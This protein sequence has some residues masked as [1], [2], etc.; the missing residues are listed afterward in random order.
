M[1]A[2]VG[3]PSSF[4]RPSLT[5]RRRPTR[6]RE[7]GVHRTRPAGQHLCR[8]SRRRSG[9]SSSFESASKTRAAATGCTMELTRRALL[10]TTAVLG[11]TAVA[12]CGVAPQIESDG[13]VLFAAPLSTIPVVGTISS[14]SVRRIYCVGRNYAAHARE[15]GS[16][17]TREPPFFFQKPR[18]AVQLV[19]RGRDDRPSLPADDEELPLRS[20]ARRGAGQG[21]RRTSRSSAR[22]DAGL[23]LRRRP[24]HDAP[25]SAAH[26]GRSAEAVGAGQ[27]VR[28][29]RGDHAP[30]PG[31]RRPATSPRARSG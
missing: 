4:P 18:D 10:H 24:R 16:D 25:R 17:P 3:S 20:G 27:G 2:R 30:A 8:R 14:F 9:S 11:T 26:D 19:A 6:R 13:N 5:T 12:G 1:R 7:H 28:Q 23:R 21:R 29:V 22:L 15:M 31:G